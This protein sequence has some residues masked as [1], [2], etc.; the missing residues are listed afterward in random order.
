M[1]IIVLALVIVAIVLAV[2]ELIRSKGTDLNAW[3]ILALAVAAALNSGVIDL[4]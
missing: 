2:I 3:A 1:T 4:G